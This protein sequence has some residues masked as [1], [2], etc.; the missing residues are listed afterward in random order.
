[1]VERLHQLRA[2]PLAGDGADF[3]GKHPFTHAQVVALAEHGNWLVQ[4][5]TPK[6]ARPAPTTRGEAS[7]VRDRFWTALQ[8]GYLEL[9]KAG[10]SLFGEDGIDAHIPALQARAASHRAAATTAPTP[11]LAAAATPSSLS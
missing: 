10:L 9:R 8:T 5:L 3:A 11:S 2:G 7:L 1:M 6:G 4:N